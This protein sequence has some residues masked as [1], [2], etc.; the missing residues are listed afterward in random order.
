M[1]KIG[2]SAVLNTFVTITIGLHR[3]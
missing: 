2:L 3:T 1:F